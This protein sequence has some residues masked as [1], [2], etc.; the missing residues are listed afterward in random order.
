MGRV[1]I[2]EDD[3]QIRK[4]LRQMLERSGHEVFDAPNGQAGCEL[5]RKNPPDL[6]ITDIF[7]PGKSGLETITQIKRDLPNMKIVAISGGARGGNI[8]FLPV[9]ESLGAFCTLKKPFSKSDLQKVLD[10]VFI[11]EKDPV[12]K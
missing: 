6:L 3:E 5:C 12:K 1:V 11:P 10:K 9:A 4:M 2:I 7:M 8:D